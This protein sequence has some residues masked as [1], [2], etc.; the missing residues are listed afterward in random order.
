[1][2]RISNIAFLLC[3]KI[4]KTVSHFSIELHIS[5]SIHRIDRI[6]KVFLVFTRF[7]FFLTED[8]ELELTSSGGVCCRI[9]QQLVKYLCSL[10]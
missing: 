6:W 9:L 3:V 10:S 1:M 2:G 8:K 5:W 7:D 4:Y